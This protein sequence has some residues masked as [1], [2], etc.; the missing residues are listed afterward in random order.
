MALS[1]DPFYLVRQDIQDTVG[2]VLGAAC[3]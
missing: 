1:T 3:M 2:D